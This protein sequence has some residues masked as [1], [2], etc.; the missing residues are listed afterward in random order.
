MSYKASPEVTR[1]IEYLK[2]AS[3]EAVYQW[4]ESRPRRETFESFF[5]YNPYS[6][7]ENVLLDRHNEIVDL[8]LAAWST[9]RETRK[10]LLLKYCVNE[11]GDQIIPDD[12]SFSNSILINLLS[13]ENIVSGLTNQCDIDFIEEDYKEKIISCTDSKN[14]FDFFDAIFAN[15]SL[16][17]ENVISISNMSGAY[18]KLPDDL[19]IGAINRLANNE[20][21]WNFEKSQIDVFAKQRF[22]QALL[23][24]CLIA[25]K[26]EES[27]GACSRLLQGI[28]NLYTIPELDDLLVR[29]VDSWSD[30]NLV[31]A[32]KLLSFDVAS[33]FDGMRANERLQFHLW[34]VAGRIGF[35]PN[36]A[37]KPVRLA[38]YAINGI[39]DHSTSSLKISDISLYSERDAA[40][41]MYANSYNSSIWSDNSVHFEFRKN[42]LEIKF[43]AGKTYPKNSS[44][45]YDMREF[46][47]KKDEAPTIPAT[48]KIIEECVSENSNF[49]KNHFDANVVFNINQNLEKMTNVIRINIASSLIILILVILFS[50]L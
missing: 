35:D 27:L 36:D 13:N 10:A 7:V 42:V 33:D 18:S 4:L 20:R 28:P 46:T 16:A 11:N 31:D 44:S 37:S 47:R 17:I 49:L 22:I 40:A 19:W 29:A 23:K 24:I 12:E 32:P 34:R 25:P 50:S 15:R 14:Y 38:A 26:N 3:P 9:E 2:R 45:V 39:S 48:K 8:A 30:E 21:I 6:K 41:F 43:S 1:T 5:T